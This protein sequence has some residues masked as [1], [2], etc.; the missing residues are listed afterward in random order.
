MRLPLG[1]IN[2]LIMHSIEENKKWNEKY[3]LIEREFNL[4]KT[5][6]TEQEQADE[7]IDAL[8]VRCHSKTSII[9]SS[10][11]FF[12]FLASDH[13]KQATVSTEPNSV[14]RI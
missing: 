11:L 5:L 6:Q 7:L 4:I 3:Q 2:L 14:R 9:I 10:L 1:A 8:K 12:F 13:S